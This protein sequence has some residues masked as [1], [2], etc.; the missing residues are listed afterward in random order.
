MTFEM[1]SAHSTSLDDVIIYSKSFGEH[2][3]HVRQVLQRLQ[4][5][6]IKL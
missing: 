1:I 5:N 3:E 4:D 6:G 2:V